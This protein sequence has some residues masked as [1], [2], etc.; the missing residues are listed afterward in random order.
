MT[1]ALIVLLPLLFAVGISFTHAVWRSGNR[2]FLE[3]LLS[4]LGLVTPFLIVLSTFSEV[5]SGEII[6]Y[7]MGGRSPLLGIV[8]EMD[9][10]TFFFSFVSL[11]LLTIVLLYSLSYPSWYKTLYL[12][13]TAGMQGVLLTRD[14]FNLYVF[15]EILSVSTY[16]LVI[17]REHRS[18][19]AS[20]KYVLLGSVAS[21]LFLLG[22]GIVYQTTGVLNIGMMTTPQ[23]KVTFLLFLTSLGIKSGI[24]PLQFW[25]PDAHYIAPS[26]VSAFLSG[27]VL[28]I[29]IYSMMRLFYTVFRENFFEMSEILMAIGVIT[30]IFGA[31]LALAQ[32]DLKRMLAYSSIHQMG[33]IFLAFSLGT[34]QGMIGALYL[35]LAHAVAKV[36]LFLCSGMIKGREIQTMK[37]TTPVRVAFLIGSVSLVGVPFTCGFIGKYYL[38]LAA[39]EQSQTL[40]VGIVLFLSVLSALYY[41]RAWYYLSESPEN[42]S[43]PYVMQIPAYIASFSSILLGVLPLMIGD[44]IELAA[45]TVGG[46]G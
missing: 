44:I 8:L 45:K 10:L 43:F 38:C 22:V 23:L 29:G 39:I 32:R 42:Y 46:G 41:F 30:A 33:I 16:I 14:L 18:Y 36:S 4:V 3:N 27:L 7:T 37:S 13:M 21:I 12:V 1:V 11:S 34:E 2:V 19:K 25:V 24:F 35:I 31:M 20:L 28:K 17:S 40:Y 26:P 9:S 15:F 5:S 6:T